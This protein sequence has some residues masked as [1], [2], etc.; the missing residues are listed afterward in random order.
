MRTGEPMYVTCTTSGRHPAGENHQMTS[1][2]ARSMRPTRTRA[3]SGAGSRQ[4]DDQCAQVGADV[5][6]ETVTGA[7]KRSWPRG[8]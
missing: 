6:L 8:A 7:A 4:G 5:H 3:A 2:Q 1:R